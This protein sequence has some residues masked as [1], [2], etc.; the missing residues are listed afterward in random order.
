MRRMWPLNLL[1]FY[2]GAAVL[3][4]PADRPAGTD[5]LPEET[6]GAAGRGTRGQSRLRYGARCQVCQGPG[7]RTESSSGHHQHSSPG[8]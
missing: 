3:A 8:R 7:R 2:I 6:K 1:L 4:L 5:N